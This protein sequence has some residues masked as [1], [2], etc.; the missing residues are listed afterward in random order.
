MTNNWLREPLLHFLL[1]GA[2]LFILYTLQNND[3]LA[4]SNR[5]V[6]SDVQIEHLV[7]L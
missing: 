5:I 2:V 3:V 1:I 4:D 7:A 6:I